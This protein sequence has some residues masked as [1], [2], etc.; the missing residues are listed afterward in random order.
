MPAANDVDVV[1]D[2]TDADDVAS[3]MFFR[4]DTSL[5]IILHCFFYG[6]GYFIVNTKILCYNQ[7]NKIELEVFI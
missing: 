4:G 1:N 7:I 5:K 2:V 3:L 6:K